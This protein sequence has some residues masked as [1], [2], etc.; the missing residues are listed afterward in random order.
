[1]YYGYV[2]IKARTERENKAVHCMSRW[3]IV[4]YIALCQIKIF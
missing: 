2:E 4:N 3:E 1:M